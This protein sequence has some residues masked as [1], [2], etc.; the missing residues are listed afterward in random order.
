MFFKTATAAHRTWDMQAQ[1]KVMKIWLERWFYGLVL[2]WLNVYHILKL[3]K[4]KI[5]KIYSTEKW[6]KSETTL[7]HKKKQNRERNNYKQNKHFIRMM[8]IAFFPFFFF[9][10]IMAIAVHW[11]LQR[12]KLRVLWGICLLFIFPCSLALSYI[13]GCVLCALSF[14]YLAV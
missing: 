14:F 10:T 2:N 6:W 7:W 11:K 12:K 13:L 3:R 5:Q 1:T 9:I 4:V 8:L